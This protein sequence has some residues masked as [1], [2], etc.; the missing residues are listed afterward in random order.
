MDEF[1]LSLLSDSSMDIFP[2][3][4]LS[5][6]QLVTQAYQGGIYGD[7]DFL[8]WKKKVLFRLKSP[9]PQSGAHY[10]CSHMASEVQKK[11]QA[12]NILFQKILPWKDRLTI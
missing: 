11:M 1:Y 10:Y 6:S 2:K 8:S 3:N 7:R 4:K 5:Y 9:G 12:D